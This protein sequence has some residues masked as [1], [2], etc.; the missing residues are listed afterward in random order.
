ME[1]FV[2]IFALYT[3][4]FSKYSPNF[5]VLFDQTEIQYLTAEVRDKSISGP[6]LS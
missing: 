5:S 3:L 6:L 1:Q 4:C 2:E